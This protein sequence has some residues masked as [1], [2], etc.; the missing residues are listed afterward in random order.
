M[1]SQYLFRKMSKLAGKFEVGNHQ[2]E[3]I[4]RNK[5]INLLK[6]REVNLSTLI[7][8]IKS[9]FIW[10]HLFLNDFFTILCTTVRIIL[11]SVFEIDC[12][13]SKDE[14]G[15]YYRNEIFSIETSS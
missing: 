15:R 8:V 2:T 7:H 1:L 11:L 13:T 3:L 12:F 9:N 6:E 5:P 4:L 10:F 14:T